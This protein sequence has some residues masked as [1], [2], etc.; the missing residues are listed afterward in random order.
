MQRFEGLLRAPKYYWDPGYP[1]ILDDRKRLESSLDGSQSL[2]LKLSRHKCYLLI[3]KSDGVGQVGVQSMIV[4]CH[5]MNIFSK[6]QPLN[7]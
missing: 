1:I 4:V 7:V 6:V 3:S 2:Y 5:A